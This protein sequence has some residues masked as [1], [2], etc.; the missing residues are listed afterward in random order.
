MFFQISDPKVSKLPKV[1]LKGAKTIDFVELFF[2]RE[3]FDDS[4]PC[5][6]N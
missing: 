1:E 2:K 3:S 4:S 6:E 5:S